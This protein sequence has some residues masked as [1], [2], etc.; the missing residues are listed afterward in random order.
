[1]ACCWQA[2]GFNR[3]RPWGT[4]ELFSLSAAVKFVSHDVK[5]GHFN[6]CAWN[7]AGRLGVQNRQTQDVYTYIKIE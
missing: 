4:S 7:L 3:Q 5:C 2:V 1:M 6:S